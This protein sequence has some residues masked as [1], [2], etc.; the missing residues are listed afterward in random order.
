MTCLAGIDVGTGSVK[1]GLFDAER[2][3]WVGFASRAIETRREGDRAEQ[4]ARDYWTAADL[5][6]R[7]L[8]HRCPT[9]LHRVRALSVTGQM[10][11]MV[12]V[13]DDGAPLAPV[14]TLHDLRARREADECIAEFGLAAIHGITGQRLDAASCPA[15]L[16]WLARHQA[17]VIKQARAILAPKDYL[18]YRLVGRTATDPIDAA[19]WLMYD[20]RTGRWHEDLCR[21]SG[22]DPDRLP[23][24][25]PACGIAG[26]LLPEVAEAWQLPAEV[27]VAV[28]G[29]DDIAASG[30]GAVAPGDVYEHLGST[31]SIF[32]VTDRPVFDPLH[33]L[34]CYPS[35]RPGMFWLGGSCNGAGAAIQDGLAKSCLAASGGIQWEQVRSALAGWDA[36]APDRRPLYLPY[37]MGE[38]CPVWDASLRGAWINLAA[39]HSP[40]DLAVAVHEGPAL[41]LGWMV[42]ELRRLGVEIRRIFSAGK[43]GEVAYYGRMRATIY[44]QPVER[45]DTPDA[46]LFGAVLIA[47]VAAGVIPGVSEG[48]VRWSRRRWIAEPDAALIG[49]YAHRLAQFRS[50]TA[51]MSGHMAHPA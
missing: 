44:G 32:A 6:M 34:E 25:E 48:V 41:L 9:E 37:A 50:W 30:C 40:A 33:I 17:D 10:R 28:G 43:A 14:M 13:G 31:G 21:F 26:P 3:A 46:A 42:A 29:G 35:E 51:L 24:I 1:A 2:G 20:L 38:R 36:A 4:D 18:R 22:I 7:E 45:L 27:V 12:L 11:A 39:E 47:G 8:A 49:G 19:G 5:A 16:L 23:R 15:K